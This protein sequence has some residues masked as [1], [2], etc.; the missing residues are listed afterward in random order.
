MEP[1]CFSRDHIS[2]FDGLMTANQKVLQIIDK[3]K[4]VAVSDLPVLIVGEKGTGKMS[5][6]TSI[7][8]HSSYKEGA[9]L[10]LESKDLDENLLQ[11]SISDCGQGTCVI[12]D[13]SLLNLASQNELLM[14]LYQSM[15]DRAVRFVVTSV[16]PLGHLVKTGQFLKNLFILLSQVTLELPSLHKRRDDIAL[17]IQYFIGEYNAEFNRQVECVSN[18]AL[19]YLIGY[20]WPGNVEE[21]RSVVKKAVALSERNILWLEDISLKIT[22]TNEAMLKGDAS[23]HLSL[24]YLEKEH[25]EKVLQIFRWNKS[26]AAKALKISRPRLD[27]KIQEYQLKKD[28]S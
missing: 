9:F 27:R 10:V 18:V 3:A 22:L 1:L 26:K 28:L 8:S 7:H 12:K 5:F 19:S 17:L 4:Q 15:Q 24:K 16:V 14:L 25:I 20:A 6:A 21:L 2:S 11:E 13:V 23:S